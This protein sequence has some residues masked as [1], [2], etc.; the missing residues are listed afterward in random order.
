MG[1]AELYTCVLAGW[2]IYYMTEVW[3]VRRPGEVL[4][5]TE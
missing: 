3:I 1:L 2:L 5:Y 4:L